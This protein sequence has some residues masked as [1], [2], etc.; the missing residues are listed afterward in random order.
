MWPICYLEQTAVYRCVG[1][2]ACNF[3]CWVVQHK[4]NAALH[5]WKGDL[6][7]ADSL[8]GYQNCIP[9]ADP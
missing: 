5:A 4:A 2:D 6:I 1:Y 8:R 3:D 9:Y 7:N